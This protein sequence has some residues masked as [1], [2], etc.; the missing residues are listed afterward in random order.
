MTVE[1][2]ST[3]SSYSTATMQGLQHEET[4]LSTNGIP[5]MLTFCVRNKTQGLRDA[6]HVC[7]EWILKNRITRYYSSEL[8]SRVHLKRTL[9]MLLCNSTL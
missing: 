2:C 3:C 5:L 6:Q 8:K 9:K 7:E 1:Y 4:L